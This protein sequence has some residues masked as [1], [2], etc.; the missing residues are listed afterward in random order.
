MSK[1]DAKR[2]RRASILVLTLWT[3]FFLAA[4]ALAVAAHV[5]ASARVARWVRD[6]TA[7]YA[8][9]RVGAAR[10]MFEAM[11]DTNRWDG[12]GER[13][14][15]PALFRDIRFGE[16]TFTVWHRATGASGPV[17]TNFG[18]VDEE[19]KISLNRAPQELLEATFREL[20]ELDSDTAKQLAAAVVDWRD[21]DDRELTGGAENNYYAALSDA[22]RCHNGDFQSIHELRFVRGISGEVFDRLRPH[23]TVFGTGKVNINT[24]GGRVLRAV[25]AAGGGEPGLC[26]SLADKLVQ[27]RGQVAG[28][29]VR[30]PG[31]A[32]VARRL[33]EEAGL[34]AAEQGVLG[35][36]M[37]YL[38][39]EG[40][41]FG[42][43]AE[44][45]IPGGTV[46][47]VDF[48]FDRAKGTRLYWHEF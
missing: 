12:T 39:L 3:L 46:A 2:A 25:A 20:G 21:P 31:T 42:G 15:D 23:V 7:G 11:S 45:W 14:C 10:A 24:A 38:T 13:W 30:E 37:G 16:G 34:S 22:V 44:G 32:D 19:S 47:R 5:D 40:S 36:M 8:L 43:T 26:A 9:A 4:L 28:S 1:C 33:S 17:T 18:L 35:R 6:D 48:V 27:V 41:C 29:A